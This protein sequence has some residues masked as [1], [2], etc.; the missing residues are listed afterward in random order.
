MTA[1]I[2]HM[3]NTAALLALPRPDAIGALQLADL[4]AGGLPVRSAERMGEVLSGMGRG[5]LHKIVSESSLRRARDGS[6]YLKRETSERL[7]DVARVFA[8]AE[9]MMGDREKALSFMRSPNPFLG[10]KSPFDLTRSSTAGAQ[11]VL[12]LIGQVRAGAYS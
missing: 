11:A 8:E 9:A 2:Y 4:V 5:T 7:Y 1:Y 12:E 10:M 3:T 6:G